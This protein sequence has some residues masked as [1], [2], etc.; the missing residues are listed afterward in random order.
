M[1][2]VCRQIIGIFKPHVKCPFGKLSLL[3]Y[4]YIDVRLTSELR[5][6]IYIYILYTFYIQAYM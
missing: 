6:T 2:T 4:I 1:Y 3:I 5:E